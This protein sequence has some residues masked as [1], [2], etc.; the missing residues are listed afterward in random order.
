MSQLEFAE[1]FSAL[2]STSLSATGLYMTAVTGY[3]IA[4]YLVGK[5]LTRSQLYIVSALFVVF[6]L[7]M[8]FAG[9]SLTERAIQL[10]VELEGELDALDLASY[11]MV[12]VQTLGIIAAL[13]FM[14]DI[15]KS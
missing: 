5:K 2:I 10:E 8:T 1:A 15:R 13:K 3:L 12:V 11:F 9:F 6:A 7:V 4:A 14:I